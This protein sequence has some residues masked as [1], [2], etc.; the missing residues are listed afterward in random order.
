LI[1]GLLLAGFLGS[2]ASATTLPSGFQESVVLSGLDFPTE[3]AFASDGRVFVAEKA[4]I[5]KVFDG[6]GDTTAT[7]FADLRTQVYNFHDHGLMGLALHPDFPTTPYVYV[8]YTLDAPIGGSAP[9][10]NDA[11]A[12]TVNGCLVS[13]R[14]SRLTAGGD[15]MTG[16]EQ[17]L[18]EDWCKQY[19][20]H[21]TDAVAFGP[22]GALYVSA[23][24]GASFNF[25]DYG[26][27]GDPLNPCGDPPAGVGGTQTA[28]TAEGGALRS[29]DLRTSSDPAGLDGT[30]IRIDSGTAAG[31]A[32]NPLAASTDANER[33]IIAHG[34]R[35]PFRFAFRPGTDQLWL[36]DVGWNAR[37]EIN[38]LADTNDAVVENFG[39]PCYEGPNRQPGYDNADLTLCEDLY[40]QT[41]A[42]TKPFFSYL[43]SQAVVSG[44]GCTEDAAA[45]KGTSIAGIAFYPGGSYP[46]A[47]D[48]ALFFADYGREC[49]WVMFENA[50][51][52]IDP[53]SRALF[54]G[55]SPT[56]VSLKLGPG[57]D[58]F[59]VDIF[60]GTVRRIRFFAG[61]QPPVAVITSDKTSGPV[62]LTVAFDGSGSSDPE[63]GTLTYAWDLDGD[64]AFDDSTAV[65][66][67]F[68]YG[69]AGTYTVRLRVSDGPGATDE[70][71]IVISAGNRPPTATIEAPLATTTW[72]VGE[73]LEFAGSGS[74]PDDGALPASA[75]SWDLI[76]HHGDHLHPLQ[77]FAGATGSF[78]APDH[79]YPSRL[80]L[81][82]TVTDS[83]GLTDADSVLLEPETLVLTLE[84]SPSGLELGFNAESAT[85]PF[86]RTVIVGSSNSLSAPSPQTSAG[87]TYVFGSWSDAGAQNHTVSATS[88]TTYT[89][90]FERTFGR[91][92][93]GVSEIG[94][95]KADVK[96][97]NKH[98]LPEPG[99]VNKIYAYVDG[100]GPGTGAQKMRMAIY[101]D[102]SGAPGALVVTSSEV[103]IADGQEPGWVGFSV[104]AGAALP[105]GSYWI[106]SHH[107]SASDT[108]RRYKVTR[109]SGTA[110]A[111]TDSYAD[112]PAN[113]FGAAS[114][115]APLFSFY[116]AYTPG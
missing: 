78:S 107:G 82:L 62:P 64:G 86:T 108:I 113:P 22:D 32:D 91:T 97:G 45:G 52:Q 105:A 39:W 43:H 47:Y 69:V 36:G 48:D 31:K 40:A 65:N 10:W 106:V 13:G 11:C 34:L 46:D 18:L 115:G 20:S 51:G 72:S 83:G 66:P 37:E 87:T 75:L 44:D 59:S 63:G 19:G 17:V 112:G 15:V 2:P 14:L 49:I 85:T 95:A 71:T 23:G 68:T 80:E 109:T 12:D 35:N 42:D 26:Q 6:L 70:D 93:V 30:I 100:K 79:E 74:D 84:S 99:T 9:T 114:D 21:A 81:R 61:N 33:R 1:V 24:D 8:A 92:T 5:V 111:N 28:P 96:A 55:E 103:T 102:S 58:L 50:A 76:L 90:I 53:A 54:A 77:E 116:A 110:K 4:G 41:G 56:P 67:S 38:R 27:K 7:V 101:A 29:Q 60:G 89:A 104:P 88:A 3:V 98:T 94:G 57:G 25:G 16:S 73:L